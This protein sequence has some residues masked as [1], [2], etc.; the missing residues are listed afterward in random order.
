MASYIPSGVESSSKRLLYRRS[1][2]C[3]SSVYR[4][5]ART[6]WTI[7]PHPP[8]PFPPSFGCISLGGLRNNR[9]TRSE[10]SV[11]NATPWANAYIQNSSKRRVMY[12][13][14]VAGIGFLF[15]TRTHDGGLSERPMANRGGP[16]TSEAAENKNS[17]GRVLEL[18]FERLRD[19]DRGLCQS[20]SY[21]QLLRLDCICV[22]MYVCVGGQ[23]W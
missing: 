12:V 19:L 1:S 21:S 7:L 17:S 15:G 10:R 3:R 9:S 16:R 20:Y 4:Y 8:P 22:W 18:P 11:M 6:T 2:T 23:K 13:R 14:T 5:C